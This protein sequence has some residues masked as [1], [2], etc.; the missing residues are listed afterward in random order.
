MFH[1]EVP[2]PDETFFCGSLVR[3]PHVSLDEQLMSALEFEKY[4]FQED[5]D[6]ASSLNSTNAGA[7]GSISFILSILCIKSDWW[8]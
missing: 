7:R 3:K 8:G 2:E 6:F 5:M 4:L 1:S